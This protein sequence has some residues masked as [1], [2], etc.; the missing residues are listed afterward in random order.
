[1]ASLRELQASFAGAL[2]DPARTCAVLP[3]ANLA[4]YRNNAS[5]TFRE[6]LARTFPVVHRRV[7]EDYFRQLAVAYRAR[8]PSRSGDLHDF[9]REFAEFLAEHLESGE[10]AWLA[11]LARLEWLRAES[12]VD[13]LAP[14]VGAE[15]LSGYAPADLERLRFM[16]QPSVRLHSSSYPVFSVW[17]ANQVENAPPVDQS[18]GEEHGMTLWRDGVTEVLSLGRRPF[19]FLSALHAGATLGDA[20]NASGFDER[21]L[22]DALTFLF[23]EKLVSGVRLDPDE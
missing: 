11:D 5:F 14:A 23:R 15:V 6:T 2:R 10:Y 16:L 13:E 8:H 12:S 7:G 19:S 3:P 18:L 4:V 20:M 9:G 22:L 21:E 17:W 1:V